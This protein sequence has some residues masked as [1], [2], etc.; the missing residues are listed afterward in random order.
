MERLIDRTLSALFRVAAYVTSRISLTSSE[1]AD[2]CKP[3]V[4]RFSPSDVEKVS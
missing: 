2:D 4:I 1:P 3:K